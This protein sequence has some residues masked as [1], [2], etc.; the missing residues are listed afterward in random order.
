MKPKTND[1]AHNCR[2]QDEA[3]VLDFYELTMAAAYHFISYHRQKE[4][5]DIFEMFVKG[6]PRADPISL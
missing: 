3:L 6:Y 1:L 5:K 2:L 4:T